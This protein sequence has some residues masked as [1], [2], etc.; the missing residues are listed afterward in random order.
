MR[1]LAHLVALASLLAA[2]VAAQPTR[3]QPMDIFN[4][5]YASNP[6]ISPDG[7]W[8][9]Y[10]RQFFD[11]MSDRRYSNLWLVR[12]DGTDNRPITTG[13]FSDGSPRWSPDGK[14]LAYISRRARSTT[15]ASPCAAVKSA[16]AST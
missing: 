13:K 3:L 15:R 5:E 11:V 4:L 14:R 1:I 9:A 12:T 7:Q 2:P 16:M 10:V 6:E 8:V